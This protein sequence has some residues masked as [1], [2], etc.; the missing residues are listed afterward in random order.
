MK[1]IE[2]ISIKI[3]KVSIYFVCTLCVSCLIFGMNS[4]KVFADTAKG[5]DISANEYIL[6]LEERSGIKEQIK[7]SDIKLKYNSDD[8]QKVTFDG[9]LLKQVLDKLSCL[10]YNKMI[11]PQNASVV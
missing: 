7:G 5:K 10:D 9:N 3:A 11:Q 1:T 6:T 4:S 2:A 8:S